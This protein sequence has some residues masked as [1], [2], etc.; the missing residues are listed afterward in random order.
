MGNLGWFPDFPDVVSMASY[1]PPAPEPKSAEPATLKCTLGE[2]VDGASHVTHLLPSKNA[3]FTA[4]DVGDDFVTLYAGA[5]AKDVPSIALK[6]PNPA[7]SDRAIVVEGSTLAVLQS[8]GLVG[9]KVRPLKSPKERRERELDGWYDV[10]NG[11]ILAGRGAL[12][13]TESGRVRKLNA[14]VPCERSD[15]TDADHGPT[16]YRPGYCGAAV[17]G[18]DGTWFGS[19]G[20]VLWSLTPGGTLLKRHGFRGSNGS[21]VLTVP[22]DTS[23][24]GV[25]LTRVVREGT[26][27][28]SIEVRPLDALLRVGEPH[29]VAK[30][31]SMRELPFCPAQPSGSL[32]RAVSSWL[33]PVDYGKP[34]PGHFIEQ[35]VLY[36][37]ENSVCRRGVGIRMATPKS[38]DLGFRAMLF[39]EAETRGVATLAH[40]LYEVT[41]EWVQGA[42]GAEGAAK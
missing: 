18:L 27:E 23:S 32:L 2:E 20:S 29:V 11:A 9:E 8:S 5:D 16:E 42:E 22:R 38:D 4:L 28:L 14:E 19:T 34:E 41:C 35:H 39:D 31:R 21:G 30:V 37:T 1:A 40:E 36:V 3:G 13:L 12:L 33:G 15:H 6:L 24:T 26:D 10:P 25:A 17:R 7:S